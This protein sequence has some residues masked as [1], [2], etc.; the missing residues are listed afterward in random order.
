MNN[1]MLYLTWYVRRFANWISL[2]GVL[3]LALLI[4]SALAYRLLVLPGQASVVEK[5]QELL[6]QKQVLANKPAQEE[7]PQQTEAELVAHFYEQFPKGSTLPDWLKRIDKAAH[8]EKLALDI[9]D[10]KLTSEKKGRVTRY[11]IQLPVVG[12]YAQIRRF[13]ASVLKQIPVAALSDI[14]LKRETS[15]ATS[16][17]AN[18]EFVLFLK[19]DAWQ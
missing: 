4:L 19:G 14:S 12:Q 2:V 11:E 15:E 7:K 17:E 8:D 1:S 6:V 5:R 13:I 18:V 3:G 16:V 9:G 10:Y